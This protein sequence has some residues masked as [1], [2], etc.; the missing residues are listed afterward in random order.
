MLEQITAYI[1]TLDPWLIYIVLIFFSFIENVF[2]PSPSDFVLIVGAAFIAKTTWGF[3]PILI[4]TS[5]GSAAGFILMYYFGE[6][7]GSKLIRSGRFKFVTQ[8]ALERADLFF[9]KYGYNIILVNRF[10][11][12]TRAIVSF[13]CGVH[14]LKAA[15]TFF[16]AGLSSFFWNAFLIFLGIL[17]G[18]NLA[19]VDYYLAQY[20]KIIIA[21]TI[22]VVI[23]FLIR[24]FMKKKK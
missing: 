7:L 3:F 18:N 1:A 8:S 24:Y 12:G 22:V 21:V 10:L 5:I 19:R 17:L 11:P 6:F 14:R 13:F 16:Y 2:P 9:H 15:R 23:L 20:S 4:L